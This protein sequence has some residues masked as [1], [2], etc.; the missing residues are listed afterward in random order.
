[1]TNLDNLIDLLAEEKE[2]TNFLVEEKRHY[3]LKVNYDNYNPTLTPFETEPTV[4]DKL[5]RLSEVRYDLARYFCEMEDLMKR[6]RREQDRYD[7]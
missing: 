1:M 7:L 4:A 5:K 3:N 2:I 6:Y